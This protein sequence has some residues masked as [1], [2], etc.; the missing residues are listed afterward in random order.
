ML[1]I[2]LYLYLFYIDIS[3]GSKYMNLFS[4]K[5]LFINNINYN[6]ILLILKSINF[7][8]FEFFHLLYDLENFIQFILYIILLLCLNFVII[9]YTF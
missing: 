9:I 8:I 1:S 6:N 3:F 7:F 5:L 4:Y 2:N